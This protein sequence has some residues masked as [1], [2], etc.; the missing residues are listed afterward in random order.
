MALFMDVHNHMSG[1]TA[2]Q[3]R[4]E[5]DKDVAEQGTEKVRFV[6]AWADPKAG[7]VFCLSE[8]P[9]RE[10][11]QRVHTKAGHPADEIYELDLQIE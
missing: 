10:A 11:V 3:L 6:K 4:E 5:H 8:G 9:D 7:K 1:I 2:E